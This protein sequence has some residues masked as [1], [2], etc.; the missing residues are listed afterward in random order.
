MS[1]LNVGSELKSKALR[2][3]DIGELH[4]DARLCHLSPQT[5]LDVAAGTSVASYKEHTA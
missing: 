4:H 1:Q 3:H 2:K 5:C